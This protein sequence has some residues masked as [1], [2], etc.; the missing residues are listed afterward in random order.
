M[1]GASSE[2]QERGLIQKVNES[3]RKN[4]NNPITI[5]S[6]DGAEIIGVIG[7]KKYSGRQ[8]TGS[9]PYTDMVLMIKNKP[10]LN[11]SMKGETAPSLAGGG[12]RG[13]ELASPGLGA[14][15]FEKVYEHL[16][17]KKKLKPGDK[18]P[19]V[20][21]QIPKKAVDKIVIGNPKMGGP[22]DFMYIG[23]MS[24]IGRYD[25]KKNVLTL[26]GNFIKAKKF[27]DDNKLFFRLRARREDQRFDPTAKDAS[28]VPKIYGRSP[29]RGDSAGRLVV[30]DEGTVPRAAER[31][32]IL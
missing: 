5:V 3:V 28:G 25:P 24:V 10:S 4:K 31:I 19:D 17:K 32:T 16:T 18:V 20:F 23:P 30:V 15:F 27:A 14:K 11:V 21:G 6:S 8:V 12:L 7:A 22:I 9:E 29:S 1:A 2:R 26:N 13:I